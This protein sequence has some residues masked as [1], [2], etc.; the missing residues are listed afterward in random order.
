MDRYQKKDNASHNHHCWS[1]KTQPILQPQVDSKVHPVFVHINMPQPNVA[2]YKASITN[3]AYLLLWHWDWRLP[4]LKNAWI[5]KFGFFGESDQL[6][7][8]RSFQVA[9]FKPVCMGQFVHLWRRG[10]VQQGI[11]LLSSCPN[12]WLKENIQRNLSKVLVQYTNSSVTER[13]S[14]PWSSTSSLSKIPQ[15]SLSKRHSEKLDWNIISKSYLWFKSVSKIQHR[16]NTQWTKY[17]E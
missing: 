15:N 14:L 17:K 8:Q 6:R 2:F 11:I 7:E 1:L 16:K 13:K 4:V 10:K 9:A 5:A 12:Q 3:S